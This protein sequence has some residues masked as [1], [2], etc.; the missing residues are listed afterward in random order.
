MGITART[1][2]PGLF[3]YT[4]ARR[5]NLTRYFNSGGTEVRANRMDPHRDHSCQR[6]GLTK[7]WHRQIAGTTVMWIPPT[8]Y[9]Q[10]VMSISRQSGIWERKTA[11]FKDVEESVLSEG[12]FNGSDFSPTGAFDS[13]SVVW[14]NSLESEAIVKAIEKI[15]STEA[16]IGEALAESRKSYR[17]V[18]DSG[19]TLLEAALAVKQRRI[20]DAWRI[21]RDDRSV[22]RRGADLYLQYK[23][24]WKPLM[25]DIHKAN[26]LLRQDL[27]KGIM[28]SGYGSAREGVSALSKVDRT[29]QGDG[30]RSCRV[31]LYGIV[32]DPYKHLAD[33]MGLTNPL[34]LA[35]ALV[36]YSFVVDWFLPV[37]RV[38]DAM[39]EPKGV[40]FVGGF[41]TTKGEISFTSTA[42]VPI[43]QSAISSRTNNVRIFSVRRRTYADWPKAGLYFNSPFRW[44]KKAS[45]SRGGSAIALLIQRLLR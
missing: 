25:S 33:Q 44:S 10:S 45:E 39:Q 29:R 16:Q 27:K 14:D 9:E 12:G 22:V 4:E 34:S 20:R 32:L 2:A 35:W 6:L 5:Y 19:R 18:Y 38:L 42:K 7:M 24:G 15:K 13:P 40:K 30:Y 41:A 26:E 3:H 31:K 37:G 11:T 36:P 23:Y 43:D 17:M 8:I 21:L 28:I 1:R